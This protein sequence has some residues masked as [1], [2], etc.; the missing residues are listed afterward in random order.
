MMTCLLVALSRGVDKLVLF[1]LRVHFCFNLL[2]PDLVPS[3]FEL[4]MATI[5]A[6]Y[7]NNMTPAQQVVEF[8]NECAY[9][10]VIVWVCQCVILGRS[11]FGLY[12]CYER[13]EYGV[14]VELLNCCFLF[15][16][17]KFV[18]NSNLWVYNFFL[19]LG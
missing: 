2:I 5:A 9:V 6:E 19:S 7:S 17:Y 16:I 1:A 15:F 14:L 8:V 13:S 4:C 11:V 18:C 3:L 12:A 10:C